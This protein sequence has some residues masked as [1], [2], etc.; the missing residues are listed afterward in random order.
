M[1]ITGLP[2]SSP[3]KNHT[4]CNINYMDLF[5][6]PSYLMWADKLVIPTPIWE[7]IKRKKYGHAGADGILKLIIDMLDSAGLV[8]KVDT[9]S[10]LT[11]DIWD[12]IDSEIEKDIALFEMLYPKENQLQSHIVLNL[13][14]NEYCFPEI[15]SVYASLYIAQQTNSNC[16]FDREAIMLCNG[17]FGLSKL[18]IGLK[19]NMELMGISEVFNTILP[20]DVWY[21]AYLVAGKCRN[22]EEMKQECHDRFLSGTEK[23]I[24][25]YLDWRE[26]DE[27]LQM[28]EVVNSIIKKKNANDG[29]LLPDDIKTEFENK[30]KKYNNMLHKRFPKIKRWTRYI[31]LLSVPAGLIS[32]STGNVVAGAIAEVIGGVSAASS[33]KLESIE[34]KHNWINFTLK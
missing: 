9:S 30:K 33:M 12:S 15:R 2:L 18:N 23:E 7:V 28:K 34:E 5:M 8:E 10:I 20:D 26:Y 32:F 16:M 21:P 25:Q 11:N 29:L 22:C 3:D 13:N 31:T 27:I 4:P 14:G 17:K 19:S 1:L 6:H 24:K